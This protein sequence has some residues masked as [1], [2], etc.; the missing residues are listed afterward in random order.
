LLL[1]S[2][3]HAKARGAKIYAEITGYGASCDAYHITKPSPDGEGGARAMKMALDDAKLAPAAIDYLNAYGTSTP[4][5]D[6]EEARGIVRVFG[7][8]ALG[9]KLWVSSTK[10]VMGHLLGAAGA[11]ETSLCALAM[12]DARVP[13]TANLEDQD[14]ECPLDCVP[15]ESRERRI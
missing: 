6:I 1:E 12:R 15:I 10:S 8:H 3:A 13:P 11:V 2:L 4:Q 7:E 5:G 14:L 9:K